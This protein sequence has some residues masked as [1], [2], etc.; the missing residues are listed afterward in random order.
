MACCETGQIIGMQTW[1]MKS[2][3]AYLGTVCLLLSAT[4]DHAFFDLSFV[5]VA[6]QIWLLVQLKTTKTFFVCD[7]N[8]FRLISWLTH[9]QTRIMRFVA[10][11]GSGMTPPSICGLSS[12]D[13]GQDGQARRPA[14]PGWCSETRHDKK[15]RS[16]RETWAC[17]A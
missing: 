7:Q 5:C 2:L 13:L 8:T 14:I 12:V 10:V 17:P 16:W 3:S 9:T 6:S 11:P 15:V 1:N 4:Q